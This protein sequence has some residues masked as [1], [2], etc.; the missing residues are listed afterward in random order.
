[1]LITAP[2]RRA[3]LDEVIR[4]PWTNQGSKTL[5]VDYIEDPKRSSK[6]T[7]HSDFVDKIIA[8]N[9]CD[10]GCHLMQVL[11]QKAPI[12]KQQIEDERKQKLEETLNQQDGSSSDDSDK[13]VS[14]DDVFDISVNDKGGRV[15]WKRLL[16]GFSRASHKF[17]GRAGTEEVQLGQPID[18]MPNRGEVVGEPGGTRPL[19]TRIFRRR[20]AT[21]SGFTDQHN[22]VQELERIQI[23][24]M[25]ANTN[26]VAP[27]T[28]KPM[29]G[30]P[31]ATKPNRFRAYT[32]TDTIPIRPAL[33]GG[34]LSPVAAIPQVP[35]TPEKEG[36]S[37]TE[38]RQVYGTS[39][40]VMRSMVVQD[41]QQSASSNGTG[42]FGRR[43]W[44]P[45][46]RLKRR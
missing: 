39:P 31:T 26:K 30:I 38:N 17:H 11:K 40:V 19:L 42:W 33:Y 14:S 32:Q 43:Q 2:R 7:I 20:V 29:P 44:F 27:Q 22:E 6:T 37:Y 8:S 3:T 21:A 1:M 24:T 10:A 28:S 4:H 36:N 18:Y 16:R 9:I 46:L 34:T 25:N 12:R 35:L 41:G 45:S 13:Q 15:W 5:S 23:P